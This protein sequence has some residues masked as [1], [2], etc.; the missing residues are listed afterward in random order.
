MKGE[1]YRWPHIHICD[2]FPAFLD[3]PGIQHAANYTGRVLKPAPPVY[4]PQKV[5]QAMAQLAQHPKSSTT[6]GSVATVLKYAHT[7]FPTLSR[8]ITAGV[9]DMYLK[10]A[11]S[12]PNTSGNVFKPVEFGT[13]IHGGWQKP[14]TQKQKK[15]SVVLII[16]GLTAGFAWISRKK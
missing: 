8:R 5:A 6:V 9:I 3:T 4:D 15:F 14:A 16:L 13:S 10:N 7:V 11:D 1:L 12:M 2:V